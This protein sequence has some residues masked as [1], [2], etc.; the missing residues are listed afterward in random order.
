MEKLENRVS[1]L[2]ILEAAALQKLD[3]E[4]GVGKRSEYLRYLVDT[5]DGSEAKKFIEAT[6]RIRSLEKIPELQARKIIDL[7]LKVQ[8]LKD[9]NRCLV[10]GKPLNI[11]EIP[12]VKDAIERHRVWINGLLERKIEI[13]RG[14]EKDRLGMTA[15]ALGVPVDELLSHIHAQLGIS[16]IDV[17]Q[18]VQPIGGV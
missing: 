10:S 15:K 1:V 14:L 9:I 13:R 11:G 8:Q 6:E 2:V 12:G 16:G 5:I 4:A 3:R 18:L 17:N 7:Q